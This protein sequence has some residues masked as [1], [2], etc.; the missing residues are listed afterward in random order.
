[1][2]KNAGIYCIRNLE[3]GKIYIGKSNDIKIRWGNHKRLL[4]IGKHDNIYLQRAWNK[5]GEVN[6]IFEVL[7]IC[8]IELLSIREIYYVALYDSNNKT[9]GYNIQIPTLDGVFIH[10]LETKIKMS[11]SQ[12]GKIKSEETKNKMSESKKG[13]TFSKEH[14][15]K[16]SNAK[17]TMSKETKMKMSNS[18]KGKKLTEETK[19]KMSNSR[20]GMNTK[21]F[22]FISPNNIIFEGNNIS[23]FA[24]ENNL[25]ADCLSRILNGKRKQHK[26][27]RKS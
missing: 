23:K 8:E 5:Y 9:V 25:N 18:R 2:N 20:K 7:E 22:K 19:M 17:L 6:F 27:W 26:G 1:M 24:M 12:K 14:K 13:K 21:V 16:M 11:K 10:S 15:T 3:N 4:K